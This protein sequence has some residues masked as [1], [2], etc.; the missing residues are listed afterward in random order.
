MHTAT[1]VYEGAQADSSR[2]ARQIAAAIAADPQAVAVMQTGTDAELLDLART[3]ADSVAYLQLTNQEGAKK[4]IAKSQPVAVA[5]VD[6]TAGGQ[7]AGPS[8]RR[9]RRPAACCRDRGRDR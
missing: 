4:A 8:R 9:R 3:Y 6:L 2:E 1:A 7:K 5:N